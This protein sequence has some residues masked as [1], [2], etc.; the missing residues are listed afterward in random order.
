[1]ESDALLQMI[2]VSD[3][4]FPIG[5]FTLSNGWETLVVQGNL[6]SPE[7]LQE[8]VDS[9]LQILP[10]GDLGTMMLACD[11]AQDH[12]Y[13]TELDAYSV[14]LK[15][16]QEVRQGSQKLCRRFL[17][18]WQQIHPYDSLEWYESALKDGACLGNHAV[19]TG[20]YAAE[21]GLKAEEAGHLYGYSL[22]NAIVTNAVKTVPLSQIS[23]QKILHECILK[24]TL[25][26]QKAKALK[27]EDLGINGVRFDL[28]A[29][30]H[31]TL[32]SRLYMS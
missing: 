29:M 2:K 9:Y 23:G 13:L 3:S 27:M 14:A 5:A 25:C 22:L 4:L 26:V 20:L 17:K 19:A 32:Y 31:E 18:L 6:D 1:M 10:Y 7:R 16:A 8:Y 11:H 30:N 24:L 21:I 28:A 12:I 15:G